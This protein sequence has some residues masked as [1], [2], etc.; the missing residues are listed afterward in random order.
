[1][2]QK[3]K[4]GDLVKLKSGGPVMTIDDYE[5]GHDIIGAIRGNPEPSWDTELVNC[6]WFD[7]K[8]QRKFGRFHQELLE[9][10]TNH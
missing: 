4:R 8:Q 2:E 5:K 1:M 7:N 9:L 6:T 10:V 3:F